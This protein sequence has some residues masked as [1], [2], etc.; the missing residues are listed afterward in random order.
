MPY[1]TEWVEPGLFLEHQGV[2]VYFTYE[3][4]DIEQGART[5]GYTIDPLCGEDECSC[6]AGECSHVFDVRDLPTWVEPPQPPFLVGANDTPAN[7]EAWRRYHEEEVE[8]R[9][10]EAAIRQAIECGF[11]PRKPANEPAS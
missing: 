9:H 8:K 6:Q 2:K 3:N 10:I 5:Y 4:G 7:R 1:S 11:L